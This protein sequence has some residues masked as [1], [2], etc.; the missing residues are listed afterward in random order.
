MG[1]K[2]GREGFKWW[3]SEG[4]EDEIKVPKGGR[5][6]FVWEIVEK[7]AKESGNRVR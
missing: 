4:G 6:P 2:T 5:L 3:L 7:A 1:E